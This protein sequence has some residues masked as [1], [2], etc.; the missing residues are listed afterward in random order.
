MDAADSNITASSSIVIVQMRT[1]RPGSYVPKVSDRRQ[2][3]DS[4]L[5]TKLGWLL[6]V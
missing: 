3:E 5:V 1:F 6:A 4:M 2:T